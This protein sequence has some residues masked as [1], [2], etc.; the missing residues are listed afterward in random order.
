MAGKEEPEN[1]KLSKESI[2]IVTKKDLLNFNSTRRSKVRLLKNLQTDR[3]EV[4][5][6]TNNRM[7]NLPQLHNSIPDKLEFSDPNMSRNMK[8]TLRQ[9]LVDKLKT[10]G[11]HNN[12]TVTSNFIKQAISDRKQKEVIEVN[13][14]VMRTTYT[15][16]LLQG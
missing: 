10:F 13:E 12:A 14:S 16:E 7:P 8:K 6:N 11:V 9:N 4:T 2:N 5:L 3:R 1:L 15:N